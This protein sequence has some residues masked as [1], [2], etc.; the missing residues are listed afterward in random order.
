MMPLWAHNP[1]D[2]L[3]SASGQLPNGRTVRHAALRRYLL[4]FAATLLPCLGSAGCAGYRVGSNTLFP[5]DIH[6]VYV[7]V[8]QS[9][10]Y[11]RNL[12][13][14]ITEE[15]VKE[16]EKRT[17]YKVVSTPNA[18]SVLSG[19]LLNETKTL[20]VESPT[21]EGR[22]SQQQYV[23]EVT[24]LDRQGMALSQGQTIHLPA[25]TAN[26]TQTTSIVPEVGQSNATAQQTLAQ[27]IARQ[28]VS[29]MENPW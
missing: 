14:Q 7:P 3:S 5:S 2:V 24:W 21:D 22:E 20:I 8:F 29:L 6:T 1:P 12:G 9:D 11:R 13:E 17:D 26:I 25:A 18:D 27:K 23:L 15:V 19:R 10:S 16:I 28:V 4:L